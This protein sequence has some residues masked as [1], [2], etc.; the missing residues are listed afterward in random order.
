[1]KLLFVAFVAVVVIGGVSLEPIPTFQGHGHDHDHGHHFRGVKS[2]K[3]AELFRHFTPIV[4]RLGAN[5][6][7]NDLL[8]KSRS[9]KSSVQI[10]P[11]IKCIKS[12]HEPTI[13]GVIEAALAF[14][15]LKKQPVLDALPDYISNLPCDTDELATNLQHNVPSSGD[16][17]DF[18]VVVDSCTDYFSKVCTDNLAGATDE[19]Q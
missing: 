14:L 8:Y 2:H 15:K 18:S 16:H 1:M 12:V 11:F 7:H 13:G 10:S 4:F 5:H 9:P 3:L 17:C 6:V 19:E